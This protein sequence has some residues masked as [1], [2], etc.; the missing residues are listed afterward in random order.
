MTKDAMAA[1]LTRLAPT[2][3]LQELDRIPDLHSENQVS[4]S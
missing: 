2:I 4:V 3:G 1:A